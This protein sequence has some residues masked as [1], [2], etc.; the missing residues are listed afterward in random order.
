MNTSFSSSF[1]WRRAENFEFLEEPSWTAALL[2]IFSLELL[3]RKGLGDHAAELV[4]GA[5]W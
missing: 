3:G 4:K 5:R 1:H 2:C